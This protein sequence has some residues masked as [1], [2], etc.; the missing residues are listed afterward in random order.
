MLFDVVL[1]PPDEL[2][3]PQPAIINARSATAEIFCFFMIES[4][5]ICFSWYQDVASLNEFKFQANVRAPKY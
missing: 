4:L 3:P 2:S 1:S 5:T